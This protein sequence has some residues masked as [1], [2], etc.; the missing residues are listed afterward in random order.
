M[1]LIV[2]TGTVNTGDVG[3]PRTVEAQL[4]TVGLMYA[5]SRVTLPLRARSSAG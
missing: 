3:G 1:L 2:P 4:R 5:T